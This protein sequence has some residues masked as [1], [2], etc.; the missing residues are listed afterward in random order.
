VTETPLPDYAA[1][2]NA[3]RQALWQVS[4]QIAA[5]IRAEQGNQSAPCP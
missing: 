1:L 3:Q 4:Q 2:V 5:T